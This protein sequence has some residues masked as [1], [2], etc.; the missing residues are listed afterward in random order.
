MG[1]VNSSEDPYGYYG[2]YGYSPAEV[3]TN[4]V[5]YIC[6]FLIR[7]LVGKVL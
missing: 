5:H 2:S 4:N 6:G 3:I 7:N 1:N